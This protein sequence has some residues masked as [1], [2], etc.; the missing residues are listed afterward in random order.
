LGFDTGV[1][2]W[3][4]TTGGFDGDGLLDLAVPNPGSSDVTVLLNQW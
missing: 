4:V 3:D 2:P 1:E